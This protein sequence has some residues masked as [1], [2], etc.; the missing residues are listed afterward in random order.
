MAILSVFSLLII[1]WMKPNDW[2]FPSNVIELKGCSWNG[3]N[4]IHTSYITS[5][6]KLNQFTDIKICV[7]TCAI[8]SNLAVWST[9]LVDIVQMGT[10]TSSA[11]FYRYVDKTSSCHCSKTVRCFWFRCEMIHFEE[12]TTVCVLCSIFWAG[13]TESF[14]LQ[15]STVIQNIRWTSAN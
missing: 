8:R 15:V 9:V 12:V 1:L 11:S 5:S 14:R 13:M 6:P 7:S 3:S 10:N 4:P 2:R